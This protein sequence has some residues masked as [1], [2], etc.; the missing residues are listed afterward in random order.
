LYSGE[1]GP[2]WYAIVIPLEAIPCVWLGARLARGPKL[3]A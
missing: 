3:I 1:L 2:A